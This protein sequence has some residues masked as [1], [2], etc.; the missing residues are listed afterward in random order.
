MTRGKKNERTSHRITELVTGMNSPQDGAGTSQ[1]S[2]TTAVSNAEARGNF[3]S[4]KMPILT[5]NK[6]AINPQMSNTTPENKIEKD[7]NKRML[8]FSPQTPTN[9]NEPAKKRIIPSQNSSNYSQSPDISSNEQPITQ[10][11]LKEM[12][13]SLQ[14]NIC[15]NMG[16]IMENIH[17]DIENLCS[18]TSHIENKMEEII[19]AHN[20]LSDAYDNANSEI[21]WLKEKITDLEDRSRRNNVKIRGIPEEVDPSNLE[22][23]IQQLLKSILPTHD[24]TLLIL[25]RA[26]RIP[27]SK[28]AP[29]NAPRDVLTRIHFYHIKDQLLQE[30]RR[31]K[32]LPEPYHNILIFPDLSASTLQARKE[33]SNITSTL[34]KNEIRYKWG[35][36]TKIIIK[37]DDTTYIIRNQEEGEKLIQQ[38][39]LTQAS[40]P[41]PAQNITQKKI[42]QE[43]KTVGK[44]GNHS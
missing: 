19:S 23:Y 21:K 33:L 44:R 7:K 15:D 14:I 6:P 30:N 4:S 38:W 17:K 35:F 40:E 8:S 13:S 16:Q 43:W 37:K 27:K 29:P 10:N 2:L 28:S 22:K 1:N 36:P 12:L 9:T 42:A 32:T 5:P 20:D 41:I 39:N 3:N 11:I 26:H 34:R 31:R 25:D 24:S 18:R